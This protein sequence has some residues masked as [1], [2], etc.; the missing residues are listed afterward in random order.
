MVDKR[1]FKDSGLQ[2]HEANPDAFRC[3]TFEYI[4]SDKKI[5]KKFCQF[6]RSYYLCLWNIIDINT[7]YLKLLCYGIDFY[8]PDNSLDFAVLMFIKHKPTKSVTEYLDELTQ[9]IRFDPD[10]KLE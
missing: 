2:Q 9:Y 8:R 4:H 10:F 5:A 7:D 1:L 6:A 3:L